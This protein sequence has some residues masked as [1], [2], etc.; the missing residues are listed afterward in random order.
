MRYRYTKLKPNRKRSGFTQKELAFL[1]GNSNDSA[2]SRYEG[3]ER[4]PDLKT[5]LA[6]KFVFGCNIRDLFPGVHAEV[7]AQVKERAKRLSEE[8]EGQGDSA[9]TKYK[10]AKLAGLQKELRDDFA[11]L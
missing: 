5:A 10:L 6:F 4:K 8:V 2:I 1:L 9:K 3:G 11:T 7:F